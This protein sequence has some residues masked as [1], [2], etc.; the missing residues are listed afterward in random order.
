MEN[1][2]IIF[3]ILSIILLIS[4][5]I[6]ICNVLT[7]SEPLLKVITSTSNN[8]NLASSRNYYIVHENNKVSKTEA[9]TPADI[10]VYYFDGHGSG[11]NDTI[12]ETLNDIA[13]NIVTLVNETKYKVL[14]VGQLFVIENRYFA[15][16]LCDR[17]RGSMNKIFEYLP[18]DN[19]II[20]IASFKSKSITHIEFYK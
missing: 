14:S 10:E 13:N 1:K 18:S 3:I 6:I 19:K 2:K 8:L 17:S 9:F 12:D 15:V 20:E 7:T 16:V 4:G 5:G 11:L